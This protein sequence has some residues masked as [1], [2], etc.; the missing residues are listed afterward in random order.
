MGSVEGRSSDSGA[1][2]ARGSRA[3]DR[4]ARARLGAEVATR[5]EEEDHLRVLDVLLQRSNILK[6]IHLCAR[7]A[8][9]EKGCV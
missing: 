4:A 8:V 7:S 1:L 2:R 5:E 6:I 9:R 3:R